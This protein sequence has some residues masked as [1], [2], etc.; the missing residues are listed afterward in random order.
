MIV[1]IISFVGKRDAER[2]IAAQQDQLAIA[3]L[4]VD[5]LRS[6]LQAEVAKA[7]ELDDLKVAL[8]SPGLR[9]IE[10]AGQKEVAPQARALVYWDTATHRWLVGASLPPAPSGKVYQ[11]WYITPSAKK[12]SAGLLK[13]DASGR[14]FTAID[15]PQDIGPIALAA[16]TLEPASGSQQPTMPI[17]AAGKVG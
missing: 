15:L 7:A 11:L 6:E 3:R 10:L 2:Q 17:Y 8:G 13:T 16:I 9:F 12:I 1:A 14:V 5:R 4:D